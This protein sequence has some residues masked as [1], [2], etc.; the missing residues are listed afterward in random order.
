MAAT[1]A[2]VIP[3]SI[4]E[5]VEHYRPLVLN[6]AARGRAKYP[7]QLRSKTTQDIE[8]DIWVAIIP[9]LDKYD[10][11][12][13]APTT[14]LQRLSDNAIFD[15]VQLRQ[16]Q[17]EPKTAVTPFETANSGEHSGPASRHGFQR[18]PLDHGAADD[19]SEV[20]INA[21]VEKIADPRA[22]QLMALLMKGVGKEAA[23]KMI[24]CSRSLVPTL[25]ARAKRD[26]GYA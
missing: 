19:L 21:V 23:A 5:W 24:G 25:V 4:E 15:M 7:I 13:A 6:R 18:D 17:N 9:R 22:R 11:S 8:N 16:F 26:L 14:F 20:E 2:R 1:K 3:T 12:K 10:P